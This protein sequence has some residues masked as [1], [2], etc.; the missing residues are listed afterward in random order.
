[1]REIWKDI[2]EWDGK[3]QASNLGRIRSTGHYGFSRHRIMQNR[4]FDGNVLKGYLSNKKMRYVLYDDLGHR[5]R[6]MGHILVA[7]A[8]PEICGE[9]FEGCQVHHKDCNSV[10]NRPENLMCLTKEEHNRIHRE[11]G[12]K[13]GE[14][15]PFYGKHHTQETKNKSA[16]RIR[17]PIIQMDMDGNDIFGWLSCTDCE[18]ETGMKKVCINRCCLGKAH[19]AYGYRWRYAS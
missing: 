19:S 13:L 5:Q 15:N 14:K 6:I 10:N 2:P 7:K 16:R 11:L 12:Q 3:Y 9:W 1:M 17:K 4:W 8:F 18:R